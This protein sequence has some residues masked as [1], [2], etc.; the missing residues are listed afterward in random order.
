M[1]VFSPLVAYS[2][3][4]RM[5][6]IAIALLAAWALYKRP[7]PEGALALI[8]GLN[9]V[10]WAG[11]MLPLQRLYGFEVGLDR[12]FNLGMAAATAAG[13]SPFEHTQVG[14]ASP[15]PF[16][17]MVLALM[18][19][20]DPVR[21]AAAF[22]WLPVLAITLI[23]AGLHFGLDAGEQTSD[24]RW[25]RVLT[26]FA[27][28]GLGSLSMSQNPVGVLWVSNLLYKP[29]HG[30]AWP[31]VAVALGMVA[32]GSPRP[33]RLGVVLALLA[34]V[35]LMDWAFVLPALVA[36]A[37]W[38]RRQR[39]GVVGRTALA[40]TIAV[41]GAIPLVIHLSRDYAP[42]AA[43]SAA[44]HM[45]R[46]GQG[47]ILSR[48]YW[49]TLD[50]GPLLVLGLAG[51]IL[52]MIRRSVRDRVL[53]AA[54]ATAWATWGASTLA[55]HAFGISPEPDELHFYLRVMMA[56]AAGAALAAAGRHVEEWWHLSPGRGA[57]L[58]LAACLPWTF[59]AYWDPPLMDRYYPGGLTPIHRRVA[60]YATWITTNT[61]RDAIFLAGDEPATYIPAL[62][63]R[64]VLMAPTKLEPRDISR[65]R[66]VARVLLSSSNP[67]EIRA[68]AATYGITHVAV[69]PTLEK[70][71]GSEILQSV[72]AS[73]AYYGVYR[74]TALWIFEV[75]PA[76]AAR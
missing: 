29:N 65:R 71:F 5:A 30:L 31:L 20:M 69:D 39:P 13:N 22:Q 58:A 45:W 27:L 50:L 7:R 68:A 70:D 8:V 40:M 19:G 66:E 60:E 26:V 54:F 44:V 33:G 42:V 15:E 11:Y 72:R 56:L 46:D 24:D 52:W 21:T 17:N 36:G 47:L 9:L 62:T 63:G 2:G 41:A 74:S 34:W 10:A 51:A 23:A 57:V 32:R 48:P 35:F 75:R 76:S 64:R 14:V 3:M 25:E 4:F 73:R 16:W 55:Y 43:S 37:I 53:L 6:L 18:S 1:T 61:A 67:A 12:A 59:T 49:S 28:F 38:I